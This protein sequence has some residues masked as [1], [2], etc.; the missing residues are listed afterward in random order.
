MADLMKYTRC[1]NG[2]FQTQGERYAVCRQC[3]AYDIILLLDKSSR[4]AWK[5][6]PYS[7]LDLAKQL[8]HYRL[9]SDAHFQ[10]GAQLG[11]GL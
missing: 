3:P 5:A 10:C 6:S 11:R 1:R 8:V 7:I 2:V 9:P 4:K